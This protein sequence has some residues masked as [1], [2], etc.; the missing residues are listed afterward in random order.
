MMNTWARTEAV[1]TLRKGNAGHRLESTSTGKQVEAVYPPGFRPGSGHYVIFVHGYNNSYG[2]ARVAFATARWWMNHLQAPARI[3]E[4]HWPGDW[5]LGILSLASYSFKV[6]VA[7][8]CGELLA[9]WIAQAPPGVEFSMVGHSLGCRLILETVKGLRKANQQRRIKSVC[10]MAA[11][12]PVRSVLKESLGAVAGDNV[13]WRILYSRGDMVLGGP[14]PLGQ[15]GAAFLLK[16]HL[17]NE[18]VGL[19]GEPAGMWN[20]NG[21]RWEM[22]DARTATAVPDYYGHGWYWPG[23]RTGHQ[24]FFRLSSDPAPHDG[25]D[26]KKLGNRGESSELMAHLFGGTRARRLRLRLPPA[27]RPLQE[28]S[29]PNYASSWI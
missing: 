17:G 5:K 18:A 3:L 11:A 26:G 10:L 25:I 16:D 24:A 21:D 2:E 13:K 4:L 15:L 14:F 19:N 29:L 9:N 27:V 1:L 8:T 28:R 22:C 7:K 12:V 6:G 20:F 23:G